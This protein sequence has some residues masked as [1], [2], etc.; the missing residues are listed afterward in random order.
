[1]PHN[2]SLSFPSLTTLRKVKR[3]MASL[4]RQQ[5]S[6]PSARA[7]EV[8]GAAGVRRKLP[9]RMTSVHMYLLSV[10]EFQ[11]SLLRTCIISHGRSRQHKLVLV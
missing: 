6:K 11:Y 9:R 2:T 5:K 10:I 4:A 8:S 3:M 7:G 1:M